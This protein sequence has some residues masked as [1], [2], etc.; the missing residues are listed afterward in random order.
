MRLVNTREASRLT[1]LST[2]QLR[3]WTSRR[4]LIPADVRPSG[5]GFQAKYSWPTILALRIALVLRRTLKV[6]LQAHRE[7]FTDLRQ[8][9]QRTSFLALWGKSLVIFGSA[10]WETIDDLRAILDGRDA[11]VVIRLD[12][13]LQVVSAGF[14]LTPSRT[15]G[16]FELFPARGLS[17]P[18]RR[19]HSSREDAVLTER[20]RQ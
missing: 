4:A 19:E 2:Q 13:H 20:G 10:D 14:G 12:S 15:A 17:S 18:Q 3:E 6:E 5:R 9:L 16:Q 1:G 8:S 7:L 11:V